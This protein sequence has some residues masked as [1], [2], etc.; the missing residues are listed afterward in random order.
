MTI[1]YFAFWPESKLFCA[2]L[3]QINEL[4]KSDKQICKIHKLASENDR[5]LVEFKD[6][7]FRSTVMNALNTTVDAIFGDDADK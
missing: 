5:N 6:E 1:F 7:L 4:K 3:R 2:A